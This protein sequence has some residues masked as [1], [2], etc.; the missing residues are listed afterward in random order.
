MT[1]E[2]PLDGKSVDSLAFRLAAVELRLQ[3]SQRI[4]TPGASCLIAVALTTSLNLLRLM[5]GVTGRRRG[6]QYLPEA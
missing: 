3:I 5:F 1:H 4:K 6:D 2:R